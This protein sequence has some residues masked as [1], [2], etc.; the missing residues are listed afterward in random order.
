MGGGGAFIILIIIFSPSYSHVRKKLKSAIFVAQ[1]RIFFSPNT[2]LTD[3]RTITD[4]FFPRTHIPFRARFV[5][6]K[7]Q[8]A[9]ES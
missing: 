8:N 2:P 9:S 1:T 4:S 5:P 6:R 7:T 3:S